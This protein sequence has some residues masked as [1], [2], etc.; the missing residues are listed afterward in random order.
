[1]RE[2]DYLELHAEVVAI[3]NDLSRLRG[4]LED[5]GRKETRF[6]FDSIANKVVGALTLSVMG[7]Y[8][9]VEGKRSLK[10]AAERS[11]DLWAD[12]EANPSHYDIRPG[13]SREADRAR[14]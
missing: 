6:W 4:R 14:R 13:T 12:V 2:A 3:R 1:M 10:A 11:R 9:L 5:V 8:E 7:L